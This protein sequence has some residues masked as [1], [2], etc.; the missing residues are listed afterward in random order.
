MVLDGYVRVSQVRGREGER[1]ISPAVQRIQRAG[2]TFVS[3]ADGFDVTTETG[4]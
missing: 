3:V 1:F 4:R 2:G